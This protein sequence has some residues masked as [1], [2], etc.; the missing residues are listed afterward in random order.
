MPVQTALFPGAHINVYTIRD[1]NDRPPPMREAVIRQFTATAVC[2]AVIVLV[3]Y[4]IMYVTKWNPTDLQ[5][6]I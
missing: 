6:E 5:I 3:V 2:T 4:S 1:R